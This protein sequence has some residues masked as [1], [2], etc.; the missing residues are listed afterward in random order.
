MT[1]DLPRVSLI[2]IFIN[3]FTP[4]LIPYPR[5]YA[6]GQAVRRT[7]EALLDDCRAAL[8]C[9]VSHWPPFRNPNQR[10][11]QMKEFQ[12]F[13]KP[14]LEQYPNLF[15]ELEEYE[16]EMAK[17]NQYPLNSKHPLINAD[18]DRLFLKHYCDGNIEWIKVL[19]Y[20]YVKKDAGHGD[21]EI[22][23]YVAVLRA[24][25]GAKSRLLLYEPVMDGICGMAYIDFEVE[26]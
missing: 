11:D 25:E 20:E 22:I 24:M 4:P 2:P 18:L 6:F 19:M 12:T 10:V 9:T 1:A 16:M 8:M 23:N 7:I 3:V 15:V 5:A 13:R 17:K 14:V 26:P 21:R